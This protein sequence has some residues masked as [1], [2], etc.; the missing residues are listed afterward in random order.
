MKWPAENS[1]AAKYAHSATCRHSAT[2]PVPIGA[3]TAATMAPTP[4]LL[5]AVAASWTRAL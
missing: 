2:W 1:A 5:N 3:T 4:R